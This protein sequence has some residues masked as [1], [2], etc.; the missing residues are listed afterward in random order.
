MSYQ[1]EDDSALEELLSKQ[2]DRKKQETSIRTSQRVSSA[3]TGRSQL[4][5]EAQQRNNDTRSSSHSLRHP[6]LLLDSQSNNVDKDDYA[7]KSMSSL[8]ASVNKSQQPL[9]KMAAWLSDVPKAD[10]MEDQNSDDPK[11][12][13]P[14]AYSGL[15]QANET[16]DSKIMDQKERIIKLL[17]DLIQENRLQQM[18][19][20]RLIQI[21][22]QQ[23]CPSFQ[24][25]LKLLDEQSISEVDRLRD[26]LK[27]EKNR[28]YS[29]KIQLAQEIDLAQNRWLQLKKQTDSHIELTERELSETISKQK[30]MINKLEDD[31]KEQLTKLTEGY[32]SKLKEEKESYEEI[33]KRREEFHKLELESKL[34]VNFNLSRL[35]TTF[36]QWQT[37]VQSTVDSFD[38][39]FKTI[40]NLL[41]KQVVEIN[42]TNTTLFEK[43][44][45]LCESYENFNRQNHELET[46]TKRLS[47]ILPSFVEFQKENESICKRTNDQLLQ[48]LLRNDA[49]KERESELEKIKN[50]ILINKEDLNRDK[51]QVGLDNCK[52]ACKEERLK[53]LLQ[54]N[55]EI[56]Y[57]LDERKRKQI[58]QEAKLETLQ[59]NLESK[60]KQI[61]EQ[62]YELHLA[63]RDFVQKQE[64]L[65]R[66]Q[67]DILE[68][69][70][71]M[72]DQLNETRSEANKLSNL[73]G[74]ARKELNQLERLQKSLIC[75]ICLDRLFYNDKQHQQQQQ[76]PINFDRF[77]DNSIEGNNWQTSIALKQLLNNNT[78]EQNQSTT[79]KEIRKAKPSSTSRA[80]NPFQMS[81]LSS[82]FD[83]SKINQQLELD[84]KHQGMEDKYIE[85]LRL[86]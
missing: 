20:Q 75:S 66:T 3:A 5:K 14:V 39:Q 60:T 78:F 77:P 42:G 44:R 48:L 9:S 76:R 18:S 52:L 10:S 68:K 7:A 36:N 56:K 73:R 58:E 55:E 81:E 35:E 19:K 26:E 33:L 46:L 53:E 38:G 49:I 13:G 45:Q 72:N 51:Y 27:D 80:N 82:E 32:K 34:K 84:A 21:I 79:R 25:L 29:L 63:R 30:D 11:K 28:V 74:K 23:V 41:G 54:R 50:E 62:N 70:K 65:M 61:K 22:L 85:L 16:G 64:D 4:Q 17:N 6:S 43:T 86:G 59:T 67:V 31:Y 37:M 1:F 57:K 71:I 47:E 15:Q 2:L 12:S 8:G 83:M 40:E 24:D 69:R